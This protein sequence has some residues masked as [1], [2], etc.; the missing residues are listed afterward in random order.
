MLARIGGLAQQS[1]FEQRG[2]RYEK[3]V[4][5]ALRETAGQLS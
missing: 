2:R 4:E 5:K 1:I 3:D